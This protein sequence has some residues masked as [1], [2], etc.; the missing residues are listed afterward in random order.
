MSH[1]PAAHGHD[2][3]PPEKPRKAPRHGPNDCYG[4]PQKKFWRIVFGVGF[5]TAS[6]T[7]ATVIL[8]NR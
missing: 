8:A 6:I 7:V 2:E 1:P 3:H 5:L 4:M